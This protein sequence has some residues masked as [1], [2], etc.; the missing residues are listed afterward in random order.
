MPQKERVKPTCA[1]EVRKILPGLS[2]ALA[3]AIIS[4]TTWWLLQD[5]W[6]KFSVLLW[7]FIYSIIASNLIPALSLDKFK[8]GIEFSSTR[9]LRW[10]IAL[11]GLT[12]SAS[13]WLKLGIW[14]VVVVLINLVIAFTFG[15]VFCRYVLKMNDTLSILLSI[16]T[17]ICGASAIAATGPALRAKA[18]EIGLSLAVITL[19]GLIAMFAYPALFNGPL[20]AWL[21]TNPLAFGMWSGIGIHETA[22]VIAAASQVNGAS[23]VAIS[24]KLIR[25]FMIGPMV[26][27]SFLLFRQFSK[28]SESEYMNLAVPWFAVAFIAFTLI[29]LGLESSG[30]SNG[31]AAFNAVFLKPAVTFLLAW[32]F[33][34][35][36]LKV[37]IASIKAIGLKAFLGG[38]AVALFA[39]IS[40]LL[41]VKFIWMPVAG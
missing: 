7:A 31:W 23:A 24:G 41:L 25:I 21:N 18:E 36:G 6:L 19:F 15:M 1:S 4:F 38:L 17:C 8:A 27:V 29:H 11:F 20:G 37:K 5:T 13:L 12:F 3:L 22:Q 28:K 10:S 32:S 35:V 34:G 33:A 14:G 2:V 40:G 16:G 26:F 39:S 30:I 9:L